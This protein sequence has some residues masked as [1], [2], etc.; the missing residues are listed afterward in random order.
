[1]TSSPVIEVLPEELVARAEQLVAQDNIGIAYTYNEPLISYEYVLDCACLAHQKSLKN[2]LVTNGMICEAPLCNLLPYIDAMNVDLKGFTQD[3]YNMVGGDLEA[4]KNT[5]RIAA[6]SCHVE[7]TTLVV[8]EKND[9][10]EEISAIAQWLAS[11]DKNIPYHISRFFP[12]YKMADVLPTPVKTVYRL[13]DIAGRYLNYVYT[14]N[15]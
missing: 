12:C 3:F 14:G 8:P 1:T 11:I 6:Q 2:V 15:C 10:E 5:I 7:V 13:A 4:V 9:S